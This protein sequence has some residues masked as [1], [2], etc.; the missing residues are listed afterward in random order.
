MRL[1]GL[2]LPGADAQP[3][4]KIARIG[5]LAADIATNLHFPEAFRRGLREHGP[6]SDLRSDRDGAL[7]LRARRHRMG[8]HAWPATQRAAWDALKRSCESTIAS[9]GSS[10]VTLCQTRLCEAG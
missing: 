7:A 3:A 2:A 4:G 10:S 5:Y 9:M 1:L 6:H 8:A